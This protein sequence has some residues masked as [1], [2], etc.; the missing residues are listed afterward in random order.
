MEQPSVTY[1]DAGRR[2]FLHWGIAAAAA[3][4]VPLPA[5]AAALGSG[6]RHL[7]FTNLHTGETLAAVYWSNGAYERNAIDEINHLLR[8]FRTG[9]VHPIDLGLL[10]LLHLLQ[11]RVKSRSPFQVISGYRSPA[12]NAKLASASRGVARRSYHMKGMAIDVA[13]EDRKLTSLRD[14]ALA[15]RAGGVGYYPKPG[16]VHVDV[17]PVRSW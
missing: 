6:Q 11:L 14:A 9:D 10:D 1:Y 15:L 7:S 16:F 13:I 8:D 12:T 3:L 5:W 2:R 17:G 4:V